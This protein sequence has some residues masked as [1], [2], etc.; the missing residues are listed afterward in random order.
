MTKTSPRRRATAKQAA[1]FSKAARDANAVT[2]RRPR[3][4]AEQEVA[5]LSLPFLDV[6]D[7][8]FDADSLYAMARHLG[9]I[10]RDRKVDIAALVESTVLALTG[11]VGTQTT[12]RA[13]YGVLTGTTLAASSFYDRF[14][15]EYAVLME[16]L[17]KRA[18]AAVRRI[19]SAHRIESPEGSLLAALG[20]VRLTDSTCEVLRRLAAGWA[21]ST[22]TKRPASIKVHSVVALG[23]SLPESY[24]ITDQKRH[25][26][27]ELDESA[28]VEGTL[29]IADLGYVNHAR[30][31][32]LVRR[33]VHF[34]RRLKGSESPRIERVVRGQASAKRCIGLTVDQALDTDVLK[35][36]PVLDLDV[37]LV[38]DNG[39][40]VT[41]RV[42][43]LEHEGVVRWYITSVPRE[44]LPAELVADAYAVRWDIELFWKALK[45]GLGLDSIRAWK[46]QAVIALV[47]AKIVAFA[48]AKLLQ[49][50][51]DRLAGRH[52]TTQ[53]AMVLALARMVPLLVAMSLVH[54]DR[55][56]VDMERQL[57]T[58]AIQLA[59]TRNS[60]RERAKHA[61]RLNS[62]SSAR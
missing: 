3:R 11:P 36:G 5:S 54:R 7:E 26:S 46:P 10:E 31:V 30:E 27:P 6:M 18:V 15:P 13:H 56:L 35:L 57:I 9:V 34:L 52:A 29:L 62:R 58:G 28:L 24:R 59:R 19:E 17:A 55:T 61:K 4:T 1:R 14:T 32:R 47:H 40:A 48:L 43:G 37:R 51:S 50:T 21:P 16:Q 20:E 53:L 45:S 41:V 42:V 23:D 25:D 12:I 44:T 49:L 60:R 39:D 2:D 33:G 22:S 8:L 38:G